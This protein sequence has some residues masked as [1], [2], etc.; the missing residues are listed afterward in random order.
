MDEFRRV[1]FYVA[2]L[3]IIASLFWGALCDSNYQENI[4]KFLKNTDNL[5][6]LLGFAAA[7]SLA[8]FALGY[9]VGTLTFGLLEVFFRLIIRGQRWGF[10]KSRYYQ[11]CL[12]ENALEQLWNIFFDEQR[13]P[14]KRRQQEYFATVMFDYGLLAKSYPE[15]HQWLMRRWSAVSINSTSAVGLIFSLFFGRC[16]PVRQIALTVWWWGP[17]VFLAIMFFI[18]AFFAWRDTK[19]MLT[20]AIQWYGQS[21]VQARPTRQ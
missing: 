5:S 3:L 17:A 11:V 12:R 1:R 8:V 20:F 13:T 4:I 19:R 6:K 15:I 21:Q 16:N 18:V 9:L 10:C 7:G 14:K 2:P